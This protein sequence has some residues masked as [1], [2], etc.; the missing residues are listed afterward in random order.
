MKIVLPPIISTSSGYIY[1]L[2][3]TMDASLHMNFQKKPLFK[4]NRIELLL[5]TTFC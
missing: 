3:R 2:C 1:S 5:H 4:K